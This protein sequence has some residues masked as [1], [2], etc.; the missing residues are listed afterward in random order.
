MRMLHAVEI[1]SRHRY[2]DFQWTDQLIAALN[3]LGDM[4]VDESSTVDDILEAVT[5][6]DPESKEA[7]LSI[8]VSFTNEFKDMMEGEKRKNKKESH[9]IFY[10][11][12]AVVV[13]STIYLVWQSGHSNIEPDTLKNFMDFGISVMKLL[14]GQP[15]D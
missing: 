1:M 14:L 12:T 4:T 5:R 9:R 15:L 11:F 7:L 8:E 10:G 13:G 6:L 2:G 3:A